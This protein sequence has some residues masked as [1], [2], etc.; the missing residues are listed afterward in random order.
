MVMMDSR[1]ITYVA[2]VWDSYKNKLL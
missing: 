1:F 2:R